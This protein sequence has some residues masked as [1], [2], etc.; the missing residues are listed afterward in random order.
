MSLFAAVLALAVCAITLRMATS[1]GGNHQAA[2]STF[3]SAGIACGPSPGA[4]EQVFLKVKATDK[5]IIV[6]RLAI[7]SVPGVIID[8]YLDH[9]DAYTQLACILSGAPGGAHG[10][11]PVDLPVSFAIT[12]DHA[13]ADSAARLR[14]IPNLLGIVTPA[15]WGAWVQRIGE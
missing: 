2:P 5:D 1:T 15:N 14:S 10:I 12:T 6:A 8:Q 7:A 3:A 4:T 13:D 9:K 11:R